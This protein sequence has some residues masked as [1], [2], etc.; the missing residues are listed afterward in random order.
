MQQQRAVLGRRKRGRGCHPPPLHH[1][2]HQQL[3][4]H[5]CLCLYPRRQ[6]FLP[7]APIPF[8]PHHLQQRMMALALLPCQRR[9]GGGGGIQRHPGGWRVYH[10]HPLPHPGTHLE[11]LACQPLPWRPHLPLGWGGVIPLGRG[12]LPSPPH[13]PSSFSRGQQTPIKTPLQD[14]SIKIPHHVYNNPLTFSLPL[15]TT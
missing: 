15:F 9:E 4:P 5:P 7:A 6:L 1:L 11:G 12:R 13:L 10:P 3:F 8:P 2:Q 14:C